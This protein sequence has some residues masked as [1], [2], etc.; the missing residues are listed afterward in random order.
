MVKDV[1]LVSIGLYVPFALG[2]GV[3]AMLLFYTGDDGYYPGMTDE[4][5]M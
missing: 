3:S 1:D 2:Y 5:A 4:W